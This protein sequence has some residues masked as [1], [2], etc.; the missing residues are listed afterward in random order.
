ML[1]RD[2]YHLTQDLERAVLKLKVTSDAK[3]R[4]EL[5]LEIRI[6]LVE[7]DCLIMQMPE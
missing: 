6:L 1:K 7:A 3:L 2:F 5:L 4:R